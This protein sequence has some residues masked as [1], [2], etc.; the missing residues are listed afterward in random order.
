VALW[1]QTPEL[2][3]IAHNGSVH[4]QGAA[5]P[6]SETVIATTTAHCR[7]EKRQ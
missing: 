3:V 4:K 2:R 6:A 7:L 1:T 5:A